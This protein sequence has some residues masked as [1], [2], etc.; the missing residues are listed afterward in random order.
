MQEFKS[1]HIR[2]S[3]LKTEKLQA[4]VSKQKSALRDAKKLISKVQAQGSFNI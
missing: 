2:Q 3:C 1:S 4:K